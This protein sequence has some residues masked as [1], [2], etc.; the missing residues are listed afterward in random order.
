MV[1]EEIAADLY[2]PGDHIFGTMSPGIEYRFNNCNPL[3]CYL[4]SLD[5]INNLDIAKVLPGH[6]KVMSKSP[7]KKNLYFKLL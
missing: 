1:I 2:R 3:G 6:K 7:Y 4:E 5:K